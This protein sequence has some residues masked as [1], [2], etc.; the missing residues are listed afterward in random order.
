MRF[1]EIEKEVIKLRISEKLSFKL[2]SRRGTQES[3]EALKQR[4]SLSSAGRPPSPVRYQ[5]IPGYAPTL[6]NRNTIQRSTILEAIPDYTKNG[7]GNG[8][9]EIEDMYDVNGA[10]EIEHINDMPEG[11][12]TMMGRRSQLDPL[13]IPEMTPNNTITMLQQQSNHVRSCGLKE[14][15]YLSILPDKDSFCLDNFELYAPKP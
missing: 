5:T 15:P 7:A 13:P 12:Y 1:R 11:A 9:Y 14:E 3:L 4:G 6:P 8:A 2:F 10:Y